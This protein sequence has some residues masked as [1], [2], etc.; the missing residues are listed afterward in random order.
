[1]TPARH[2]NQ[3]GH[4]MSNRLRA[5]DADRDRAARLLGVHFAAGRLTPDEFCDRLAA[6]LSAVTFT[7]LGE[8]LDVLRLGKRRLSR[9]SYRPAALMLVPAQLSV[10]PA[11]WARIGHDHVARRRFPS[12]RIS[13]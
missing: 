2:D 1:M 11:T 5:G 8:I 9:R 12:K 6:A 7:D 4:L 3:T 10:R 13:S